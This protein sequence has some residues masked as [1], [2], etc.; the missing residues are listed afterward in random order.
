[1]K[2]DYNKYA[3]NIGGNVSEV[4]IQQNTVSSTQVHTIN[5]LFDYDKVLAVLQEIY[6]YEPMF[7]DVYG[8]KT[9]LMIETLNNTKMAVEN[10]EEKSKIKKSIDLIKKISMDVSSNL[11]AAGILNLLDKVKF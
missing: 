4:Q 1:M 8:S 9:N 5:E 11:I 6:K 7:K 10:R 3:V 2:N